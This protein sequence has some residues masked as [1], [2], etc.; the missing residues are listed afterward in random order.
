[1]K[2]TR[3]PRKKSRRPDPARVLRRFIRLLERRVAAP[4]P[5]VRGGAP[6]AGLA[7]REKA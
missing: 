1:M 4:P 3:L 2:L 6:F 5:L 7:H